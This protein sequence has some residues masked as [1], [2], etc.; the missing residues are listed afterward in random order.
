MRAGQ[1]SRREGE[2]DGGNRSLRLILPF[3]FFSLALSCPLPLPVSRCCFSAFNRRVGLHVHKCIRW[4]ALYWVIECACVYL[5]ASMRTVRAATRIREWLTLSSMVVEH[6][7][8]VR[9]Q[10]DAVSFVLQ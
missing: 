4:K 6:T 9:T 3:S 1:K 5:R 10:S 7:G 2:K 8:R